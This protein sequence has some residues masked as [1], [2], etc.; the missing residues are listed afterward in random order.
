MKK[1]NQILR[2]CPFLFPKLFNTAQQKRGTRLSRDMEIKACAT[3]EI[4]RR[5]FFLSRH[6]DFRGKVKK[7]RVGLMKTEGEKISGPKV[8]KTL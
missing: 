2:V 3:G 6:E 1:K 8:S 5:F 7:I 4:A